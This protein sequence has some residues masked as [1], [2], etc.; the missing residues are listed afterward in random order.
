MSNLLSVRLKRE[1]AEE[2]MDTAQRLIKAFLDGGPCVVVHEYDP[3]AHRHSWRIQ[4]RPRQI[5]HYV[6]VVL[7]DALYNFRSAL[8]HL[9]HQLVLRNGETP[10]RS[11]AFPICARTLQWDSSAREQRT[12]GM[13]EDAIAFIKDVQPCFTQDFPFYEGLGRLEAL[14]NFDKHNRLNLVVTYITWIGF[15]HPMPPPPSELRTGPAEDGTLIAWIE[16]DE[17]DVKLEYDFGVAFDPTGPAGGV[18]VELVFVD[19]AEAVQRIVEQ[20]ERKFW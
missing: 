12:R 2:H 7:G 6:S 17:S 3:K 15:I 1:R 13:H 14:S 18:P 4:G 19:I 16:T 11:N 5:G 20:F 9:A 8:D 10:D